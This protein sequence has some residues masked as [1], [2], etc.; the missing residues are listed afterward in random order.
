ML[1]EQAVGYDVGVTLGP[2]MEDAKVTIN[3]KPLQHV[4]SASVR[5][6]RDGPEV[7]S[8]LRA[9]RVKIEGEVTK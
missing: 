9:S 8:T 7:V 3:G 2:R 5:S 6:G 1:K 4:V